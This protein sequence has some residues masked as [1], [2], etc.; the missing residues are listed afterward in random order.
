MNIEELFVLVGLLRLVTTGS[1]A[2]T[3]NGRCPDA[4]EGSRSRD[5]NCPACQVI[6]QADRVVE[7]GA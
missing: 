7:R 1:L 2:H 6:A 5:P 3:Y 4:V